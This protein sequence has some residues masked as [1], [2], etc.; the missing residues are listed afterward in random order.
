M[1]EKS[2]PHEHPM[3]GQMLIRVRDWHSSDSEDQSTGP[4]PVTEL[5]RANA[6]TSAVDYTQRKMHRPVLDLDVPAK[7]IPSTTEGHHHLLIDVPMSW[8]QYQKL[9]TVL[10]EVGIVEPGY[11]QASVARGY[12]AV[13]LPWV[14]KDA[15]VKSGP[16]LDEILTSDAV[17]AL[18]NGA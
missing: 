11:T 10:A 7:L 4:E 15:K 13:R 9:M 6:V 14:K 5:D 8:E 1:D 16:T 2:I 12:S 3:P 17:K 18:R